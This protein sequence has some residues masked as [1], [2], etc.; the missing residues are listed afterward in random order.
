MDT[1]RSRYGGTPAEPPEPSPIP[2]SQQDVLESE[3][4]GRRTCY[5]YRAGRLGG[6]AVGR[7]RQRLQPR[8]LAGRPPRRPTM[9]ATARRR[10][11]LE[12]STRRADLHER[13]QC[14][15]R[16]AARTRIGESEST[17]RR[18]LRSHQAT[19]RS[20]SWAGTPAPRACLLG[21]PHHLPTVPAFKFYVTTG[22]ASPRGADTRT[23]NAFVFAQ[24]PAASSAQLSG[25]LHQRRHRTGAGTEPTTEQ[26]HN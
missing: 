4:H 21:C 26:R 13:R 17:A 5:R 6:A 20:R 15:S 8:V 10:W 18:S 16:P 3:Y 1:S 19:A 2:P 22:R 24:P 7:V 14:Q 25:R 23:N 9:R 12:W 11:L